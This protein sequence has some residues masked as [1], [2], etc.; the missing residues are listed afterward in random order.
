[1]YQRRREAHMKLPI[2]FRG[3]RGKR[4]KNPTPS[5][6]P[7]PA[8]PIVA[9][10]LTEQDLEQVQGGVLGPEY[11]VHKHLAGVKYED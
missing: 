5:T 10:E 6:Q 7:A 8:Q 4:D 3:A 11:I 2:V 1:M 9:K